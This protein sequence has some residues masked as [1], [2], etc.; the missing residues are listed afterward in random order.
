MKYLYISFVFI[1]VLM[2]AGCKKE[3]PSGPKE[4][5]Q[6]NLPA[7][8]S[9]LITH[10]N[11]F[12]VDL[13]RTVAMTENQN[14]MISP[15][16]ASVAL[17]M[18]LNGCKN[19]TYDQI[20]QMLGFEGQ[21]LEEINDTYRS[22]GGQLLTIDPEVKLALANAVFY[23]SGSINIH[24]SYLDAMENVFDAHIEGL[25]FTSPSALDV[26]NGWAKDNTYGKIDKVID[27][28]DP[29]MV[30]FLMNALYF[31][32][33]WTCQFDKNQTAQGTFHLDDGS[34]TQV[35][36][37]HGIINAWTHSETDFS[38]VEIP[39]GRKNFSMIVIVPAGTL[40]DFIA[41]FDSLKYSHITTVLGQPEEPPEYMVTM[42]K[43]TFKYE[44]L[45]NNQ[46][47][48]LGMTDAFDVFLADLTGIGEPDLYVGFVK[49]N[50][51]VDVNEEGTEAAAVTTIAV[52]TT[53]SPSEFIV[54]KPFI[55]AIRERTTN[56]LLFIGKVEV[57]ED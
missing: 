3:S 16:S 6:L 32:G 10:S 2:A 20:Q 45:L 14:I 56:T 12:G 33:T 18:L 44:K 15:L 28:I 46:L 48:A 31:K 26:I 25:D 47:K 21:T 38:A 50:T 27:H 55:F 51:F 19:T 37:M 30:M 53:A 22:L 57:P 36:M 4:P 52:G 1:L 40:S 23:Y 13:F 5:A 43:F 41:E 42:P 29:Y 49:Q 39:Y 35:E 54:D 24:Q 17:T 11:G 7:K 34:T 8:A 9:E